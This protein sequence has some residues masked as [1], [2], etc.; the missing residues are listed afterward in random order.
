MACKAEKAE[1]SNMTKRRMIGWYHQK[2]E[3]KEVS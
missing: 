1:D 2:C 3:K